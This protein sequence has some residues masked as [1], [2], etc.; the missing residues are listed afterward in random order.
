MKILRYLFIIIALGFMLSL[1]YQQSA[2]ILQLDLKLS[3]PFMLLGII[4]ITVLF[5]LDAYGWLLIL[6]VLGHHPP[7]LRAIRIWMIS[8][9]ARYIPGGIWSY[10]SR[11][12]LARRENIGIA[13][14]SLSLLLETAML[15][16][17]S[18]V[19]GLPALLQASG[20]Q[21]GLWHALGMFF[22]L[23]LCMHPKMLT[24]LRFMPGRVGKAFA[25]VALPS[26]GHIFTIYCYYVLF[27]CLFG[28]AF[29]V[30]SNMIFPLDYE[31][32]LPVG[33]SLALGFFAGFII[34]FVPGGIGVRETT[35]YFLLVPHMPD[36]QALLLAIT[37]RLWIMCGEL[38]SLVLIET[39][40]RITDKTKTVHPAL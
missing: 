28:L 26:L 37:S 29:V 38:L 4:G 31:I 25:N 35:L 24:M 19:I 5:I 1:L 14:S 17:S 11:A 22:F 23:G 8:S 13:T 39:L 34:L 20:L 21:F 27:W 7:V 6:R 12:E 15:A 2:Q 33:S 9:I 40:F 32:W 30:F 36:A 16:S 3:I 18:L 10:A